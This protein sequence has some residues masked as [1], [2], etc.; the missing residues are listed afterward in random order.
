MPHII[1]AIFPVLCMEPEKYTVRRQAYL[2]MMVHFELLCFRILLLGCFVNYPLMHESMC[3][4]T[5]LCVT[6]CRGRGLE[7]HLMGLPSSSHRHTT[8]ASIPWSLSTR[9]ADNTSSFLGLVIV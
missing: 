6:V 7:E 1:I 5:C 2:I 9:H 3:L 8:L 4:H